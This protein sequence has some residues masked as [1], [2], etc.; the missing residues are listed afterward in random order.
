MISV[1]A[2]SGVGYAAPPPSTPEFIRIFKENV[3]KSQLT[4]DGSEV[5]DV[6]WVDNCR[7][8]FLTKNGDIKI[9]W[10]NTKDD[11]EIHN[12]SADKYPFD[13]FSE[14]I[15][16]PEKKYNFFYKYNDYGQRLRMIIH[17]FSTC[18]MEMRKKYNFYMN[19][20]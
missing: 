13:V 16:F 20:N 8:T 12:Y 11:Y 6:M 14:L 5:Y 9:D 1:T 3:K 4:I 17:K 7:M 10:N 2:L 15:L 18:S 19:D